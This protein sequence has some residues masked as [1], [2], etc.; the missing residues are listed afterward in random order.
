MKEWILICNNNH[1]DIKN[2]FK[3]ND[4][5]TWPQ[6]AG[7][8]KGDIIYFY[9]TSPYRALLYKCQVESIDLYQ[10]DENTKNYVIHT[11]FY[12]KRQLYIRLR[13][14]KTYPKDFL[15]DEKLKRYEVYNFQSTMELPQELSKYLNKNN[16]QMSIDAK[17]HLISI[18]IIIGV[19]IMAVVIMF[20]YIIV[21]QGG[22]EHVS[23][24]QNVQK[25]DSIDLSQQEQVTEESSPIKKEKLVLATNAYF[26][27]YEYYEGEEIVGL[28]IEIA[29]AI[30]ERLGCELVIHNLPFEEIAQS[31]GAGEAD[32]GLSGM[33]ETV[34]RLEYV[35]FT[36]TYL[37]NVQSIMVKN[38]SKINSRDELYNKTIGVI[39]NTTGDIYGT[40]EYGEEHII[41]YD[42]G[43]DAALALIEENID[44]VILDKQ[45]VERYKNVDVNLKILDEQYI[46]ESYSV[47]VAK[48]NEKLLE[49]INNI[50]FELKKD[51]TIQGIINKYI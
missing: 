21:S 35:D 31:V 29:E 24:Q 32:I 20:V 27:P 11:S 16:N 15:T 33:T 3:N 36:D 51:G 2:A 43:I 10:M 7:I 47:C 49:L 37:T 45:S 26:P 22:E 34:E 12:Q 38:N 46:E 39:S 42:N 41:K 13:Y 19:I 50:L 40:A 23:D 30:A 18:K 1:F 9:V 25:M 4:T 28:D 5:I 44:A 6:E 48:D 8:A 17:T 14:I